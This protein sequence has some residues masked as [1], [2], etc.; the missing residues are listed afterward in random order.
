VFASRSAKVA[1]I[2]SEGLVHAGASDHQFI[3]SFLVT[4]AAG[5][6]IEDCSRW[7]PAYTSA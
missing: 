1:R 3:R 7:M 6:G 5:H 2:A 4:V